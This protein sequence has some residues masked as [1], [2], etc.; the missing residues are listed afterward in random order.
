[1]AA[2]VGA[3]EGEDAEGAEDATAEE[4]CAAEFK[5]VVQLEEVE[6]TSGEEEEE[7]LFDV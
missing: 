6:V 7:A 1:M 3:T 2:K 5:P 4:E